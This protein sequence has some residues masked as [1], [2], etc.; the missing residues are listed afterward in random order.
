MLANSTN[1]LLDGFVQKLLSLST[2]V[3][4]PVVTRVSV[5]TLH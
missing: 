2:L 5:W 4:T 3:A 1:P